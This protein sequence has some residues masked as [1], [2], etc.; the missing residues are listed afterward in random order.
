MVL[1]CTMAVK[2]AA[3]ESIEGPHFTLVM[4]ACAVVGALY[5]EQIITSHAR[6]PGHSS[7]ND[8]DISPFQGLA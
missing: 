4:H 6:L 8:D 2:F 7:R 3:D 1:T 5:L